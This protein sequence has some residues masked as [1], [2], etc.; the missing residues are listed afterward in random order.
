MAVSEPSFRELL[1]WA[2][3]RLEGPR[4]AEIAAWV[5]QD[6][7]AAASVAWI[8]SFHEAS[9]LMPLATPPEAQRAALRRAIDDYV[10]PWAPTTYTVGAL[11]V[12]TRGPGTARGTRGAG[13]DAGSLLDLVFDTELGAIRVAV[14]P[15]DD[16]GPL[17]RLSMG[18]EAAAALESG[19]PRVVLTAGERVRR[20]A[21]R[22][23]A[24]EFEAAGV[25]R[26]VDQIWLD[27]ARWHIRLSPPG[28]WRG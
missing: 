1:D 24:T 17:V 19:T 5:P 11:A 26:D 28:D 7:E 9:R 6:T 22:V 20:V 23:S 16:E 15:G 3:G 10:R 4:Y 8:R 18:E 2:E 21:R 25:P 13:A 12:A 14:L 27:H